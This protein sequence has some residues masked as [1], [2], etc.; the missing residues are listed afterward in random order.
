MRYRIAKKLLILIALFLLFN[1][2]VFAN[3]N[4]KFGI[5]LAQPHFEDIDAS[6][7]LVN[8]S[9]GD[10]GYITLVIQE[11]D[12]N[13]SKWQEIFERLRKKHLIP[14]IRLATKP[15]GNYWKRPTLDEGDNWVNFLDSLNWIVKDRYVILF[16]EPNH[17]SEWG[18]AV[19]TDS[20]AE[21][22]LA[23]AQKL[24]EKNNL[25]FVMLAG[26]DAS[27]PSLLPNYEDEGNFLRRV[28]EKIPKDDFEKYIDGWSSHSYPNPGFSGS[29]NGYGRGTVRT[30]QWELSL[31]RELG[32]EKNLPVLITET[33]WSDK[34]ISRDIIANYFRTAFEAVWLPDER[35]VAVTPFVFNYQGEPFIDFSWKRLI[36]SSSVNASEKQD[37][38]PQ[39]YQVQAMS[40]TKGD[41]SI[42]EAGKI[43]FDAPAELVANSSYDF[44]LKI[45]NVGQAIW[46]K[47]SG[48]FLS[49]EG[50]PKEKYFFS[51]LKNIKP[52]E[53]TE[54]DLFLKTNG[55]LGPNQGKIILYKGDK[56]VLGSEDWKFNIS[57]LPSL[58]FKVSA[59][60]KLQ[61]EGDDFEI[62]IFDEG[63]NLILKRSGIRVRKGI[64]YLDDI[65]NI[66]LEKK[67]RVVILR[68]YYL[69]RQATITF[70]G[71]DNQLK[72]ERMLPL[73]FNADGKLSLSDMAAFTKNWR[74]LK[75]FFP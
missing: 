65:Q 57:P 12:R 39:Y 32:I 36:G 69:P 9:G 31:L 51:D 58:E 71:E 18:G 33:G 10:W 5:H 41:P 46:D 50:F 27:A 53:E 43:I 28:L 52:F 34:K 21:I 2:P 44:K 7:D 75:M 23:Y 49:L 62:Q 68:P 55:T 74:L 20:Y 64:G 73:D 4:N 16:N 26:L 6:A 1:S 59:Y 8:A 38:Y 11:D 54:V 37:F 14:I 48:Y 63:Q 29:P 56:E 24:K 42:I 61:T 13:R 15:E 66:I 19:D 67:Y 22:A 25:F 60:P 70:K 35:V 17:A 47:D 40:K 72:F 45:K 3:E 30:Y